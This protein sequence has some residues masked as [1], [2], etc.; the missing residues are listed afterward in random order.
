MLKVIDHTNHPSWTPINVRLGREN[1]AKTY[2]MDIVKFYAPVFK[3]VFAG[4]GKV[5]LITVQNW[6]SCEKWK[7][8]DKIFVFVHERG[9]TEEV[10]VKKREA[11]KKFA[12]VNSQSEVWFIV[13]CPQHEKELKDE[14]LNCFYLPMAIDVDKFLPYKSINKN[15]GKKFI[16]YGNL[17]NDK[18]PAFM[19]LKVMVESNGWKLDYISMDR[20]NGYGFRLSPDKIRRRLARYKYGFA[21]GRSAQEL[22]VMGVKVVCYSTND[23]MFARTDEESKKLL[24]QNNTSWGEGLSLEEFSKFLD[25]KELDKIQPRFN[26]CKD[27]AKV[28]EKKL[29]DTLN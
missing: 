2:S 14:G 29:L 24:E 15:L 8:Y 1:G 5:L 6:N 21:V 25:E 19:K 27:I 22:S 3:R 11:L 20:L 13:W 17:L 16:Y 18:V 10:R 9:G 12:E 4:R 26:D 23:V 28:L 7:G